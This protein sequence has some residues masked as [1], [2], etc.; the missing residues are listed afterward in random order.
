MGPPERTQG[1]FPKQ[2]D[3][4]MFL[5]GEPID[6]I[7]T[8]QARVVRLATETEMWSARCQM[9]YPGQTTDIAARNVAFG[10]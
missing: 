4:G 6:K 2:F 9:L 3:R 10:E 5:L 8:F 1:W 7:R